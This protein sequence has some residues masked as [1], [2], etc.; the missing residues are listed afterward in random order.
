MPF[1]QLC[2]LDSTK[3]PE[4]RKHTHNT[5]KMNVHLNDEQKKSSEHLYMNSDGDISTDTDI[6]IHFVFVTEWKP[7]CR[8]CLD[9]PCFHAQIFFPPCIYLKRFSQMVDFDSI[10]DYNANANTCVAG[11]AFYLLTCR[12]LMRSYLWYTIQT[13]ARDKQTN[14]TK[15]SICARNEAVTSLSKESTSPYRAHP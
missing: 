15:R 3:E 4:Q 10:K 6:Y 9:L 14:I 8:S 13:R 1:G 2:C 5:I 12:R 11:Y 7:I